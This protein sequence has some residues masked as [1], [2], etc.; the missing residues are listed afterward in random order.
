MLLA[1]R[2][3]LIGHLP[4]LMVALDSCPQSL[5]QTNSKLGKS[6]LI[7]Y[8]EFRQDGADSVPARSFASAEAA[9]ML[10]HAACGYRPRFGHQKLALHAAVTEHGL[11]PYQA[12]DRLADC[13]AICRSKFARFQ[14]AGSI[15]E[16]F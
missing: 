12:S 15:D 2:K 3:Q 4:Q 11:L 13:L 14:Q 8:A 10:A 9:T 7:L 5:H 1:E 16:D 6:Y